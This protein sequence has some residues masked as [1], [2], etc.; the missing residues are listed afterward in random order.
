VPDAK[1]VIGVRK[2]T[3]HYSYNMRISIGDE[4]YRIRQFGYIID[5]FNYFKHIFEVQYFF[6][7]YERASGLKRFITR[8]YVDNVD[9]RHLVTI[10][11]VY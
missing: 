8:N 10:C 7:E 3:A 6:R 2:Y 9:E 4:D 11:S 1:N 5:L